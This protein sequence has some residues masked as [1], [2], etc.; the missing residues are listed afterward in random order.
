MK[1]GEKFIM[2]KDLRKERV[3]IFEET[4]NLY[5]TNKRLVDSV[6]YS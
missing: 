2:Y 5:S 3:E 4:K 1:L 6:N